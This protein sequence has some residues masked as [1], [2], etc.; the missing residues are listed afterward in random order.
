M[1]IYEPSGANGIKEWLWVIA[2][3]FDGIGC[4]RVLDKNPKNQR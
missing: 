2:S 3:R 4:D 1:T